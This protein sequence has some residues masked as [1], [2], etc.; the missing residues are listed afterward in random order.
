MYL[1]HNFMKNYFTLFVTTLLVLMFTSAQAQDAFTKFE[2]QKNMNNVV[3]TKKMFELM[4]NVKVDLSNPQEKA[5]FDL[6]KKLELLRVL[7]SKDEQ[8]S[9]ELKNT[10]TAYVAAGKHKKLKEDN[11]TGAVTYINK[12]GNEQNIQEFIMLNSKGVLT[13]VVLIKGQFNLKELHILSNKMDL[14]IENLK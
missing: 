7:N 14:P 9:T 12:D 3:V 4:S 2:K 5:Y 10:T 13:T 11:T 8:T 6:I 1:E